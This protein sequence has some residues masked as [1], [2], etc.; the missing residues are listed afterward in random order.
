MGCDGESPSFASSLYHKQQRHI[1][2]H[3]STSCKAIILGGIAVRTHW[4]AADKQD[5]EDDDRVFGA[6]ASGQVH[7][8]DDEHT[9]KGDKSDRDLDQAQNLHHIC[10]RHI[11]CLAS[12][13]QT[14]KHYN[15]TA[16][17]QHEI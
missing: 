5:E 8:E 10:R 9:R 15:L 7:D 17:I 13:R 1:S 16:D 12:Q 11:S 6:F 3:D 4:N 2:G 14:L